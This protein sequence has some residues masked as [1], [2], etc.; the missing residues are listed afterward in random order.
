MPSSM[1]N[2][3]KRTSAK[4]AASAAVLALFSASAN[5][6]TVEFWSPFT[7]PDG[8]T[9]EAMIAEFNETRGAEVDASVNL[10][11]VP[12]EQYYT[13]LT[14]SLASGTAPD[15]AIAHSHRVAGFVGQGAL[16]PFSD[17][18]LAEVGIEAGDFVP[19]LWDAGEIEGARY[20]IPIDAFPRH[21]Y[22]NKKL[23]REAG[24][25]PESPPETG[26]ELR[27]AAEAISALGD[28]IYGVF[29][30][31]QGAW[32]AR[33]FY[34]VYWQ[35]TPELLSDDGRTVSES[36]KEAA[37][38]SLRQLKSLI[39]DGLA[40]AQDIEEYESL[41]LQDRIGIAISQIT[42]LPL[43]RDT[44]GLDYGAGP[45]PTLGNNAATF[46]LGHNFAIPRD[47]SD[48][49]RESA[50]EFIRWFSEHS[51]DW[52]RDG[53]LPASI[54]VLESEGFA[55]LEP[56]NTIAQQLDAMKLPPMIQA[57]PEIDRIVRE[58]AEAVYAGRLSV[59]DAAA[60]MAAEIDSALASQ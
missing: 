18:D 22:Y 16:A 20:A 6:A 38:S 54:S 50:L 40:P 33:D 57:Q 19:A 59:E 15:L 60:G 46:A 45:M 12:W 1:A 30:R 47:T 58:H 41:F 44:E 10:L 8:A 31:L 42:D 28:N 4:L 39:D 51:L 21:T 49:A 14:V 56:H 53:K 25:D 17:D 11:I 3:K 23:F 5:A 36:F 2:I 55:T 34:S 13:K 48:E 24:L 7:G 35:Y 32:T 26:E 29:F 37:T 43:F 9:I 52:A 27:A